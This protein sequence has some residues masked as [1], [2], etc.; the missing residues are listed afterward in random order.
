MFE[1]RRRNDRFTENN[2]PARS[3]VSPDYHGKNRRSQRRREAG[4]SILHGDRVTHKID[5]ALGCIA[6][7]TIDSAI[8]LETEHNYFVPLQ[9]VYESNCAMRIFDVE[10]LK[11]P[12]VFSLRSRFARNGSFLPGRGA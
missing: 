8:A 7:W 10:D 4:R 9:R 6:P 2:L 11:E 12:D 5:R 1:S 3:A